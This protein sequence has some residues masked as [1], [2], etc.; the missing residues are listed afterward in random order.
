MYRDLWRHEECDPYRSR[1]FGAEESAW[2]RS[3]R[4]FSKL[5]NTKGAFHVNTNK[6]SLGTRLGACGLVGLSSLAAV[7]YGC[8]SSSSTPTPAQP[9]DSGVET[10][11]TTVTPPAPDSGGDSGTPP[12]TTPDGGTTLIQQKVAQTNLFADTAD[13]GAQNVDPNLVNSWGLAFNPT[14]IAWISDNGTGLATL[15]KTNQA[16]PVPLVVQIPL[17]SGDGGALYPAADADT[18]AAPSGQIFNASAAVPDAGTTSDFMG[19]FFIIS[20]E[21]GTISGWNPSLTDTTK[22]ALR[23]D[24]SGANAIFKGLAILPTTPQVLVAADFHNG[25]I[26]AFDANYA[27]IAAVTGKWVDTTVP[28]GFAPFNIVVTGSNVLVAYAKQD[29]DQHDDV[30]GPGNGAVSVFDMTGTLVKSLIPQNAG[31]A[32]NS[33]WGMT[34]VPA[35]GWGSLPAG[36][37]LVGNFGDGSVHAYNATSGALIGSLATSAGGL[38]KIDGLWSLAWG[39]NAPEAGATPE[40]LYF[41]AGPN[42]ESNGLYGYLTAQ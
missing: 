26:D 27:P 42:G 19:D 21:D 17:P 36:A 11:S 2:F 23:V 9:T 33:P 34:I 35:G 28:A 10:D 39:P 37:L 16:S 14:G 18:F 38:L 31:S 29:S 30:A 7:F 15:Y 20:A 13:G 41:T 25:L 1:S 12:T 24:M 22:A 4:V 32:L 40:Q 8:S 3:A 6:S 5:D